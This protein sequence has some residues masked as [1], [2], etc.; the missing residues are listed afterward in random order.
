MQHEPF[1]NARRELCVGGV[2]RMNLSAPF[3]AGLT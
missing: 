2:L 3:R 1:R